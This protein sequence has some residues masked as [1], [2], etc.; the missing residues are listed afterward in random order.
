MV[1]EYFYR[2]HTTFYN[3]HRSYIDEASEQ[4]INKPNNYQY[5]TSTNHESLYM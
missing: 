3:V 4:R 2:Y 1:E 5:R